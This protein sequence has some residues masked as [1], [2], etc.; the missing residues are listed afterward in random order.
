MNRYFVAFVLTF[1][2]IGFGLFLIKFFDDARVNALLESVEASNI[3]LQAARQISD[4]DDVFGRSP[5]YCSVLF[6]AINSQSAFIG[7][8]FSELQAA[9]KQNF[10]GNLDLLKKKYHVQNIQ[11]YL[12]FEK[13]VKNCSSRNLP[14]VFFYYNNS[15]CADCVSQGKVLDIVGSNCKN[16]RIFAF[17]IDIGLPFVELLMASKGIN[18]A[19]SVIV[20]SRTFTGLVS[21]Q[22]IISSLPEGY[23]E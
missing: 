11:L 1:L 8:V 20:G 15:Y 14:I 7:K 19:P 21:E 9:E 12:L 22:Q 6:K 4:Y 18:S 3:D 10:L 17:P 13:A 23:C 16:I 5:N 2:T